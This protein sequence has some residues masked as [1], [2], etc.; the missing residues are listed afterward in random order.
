MRWAAR[1]TRVQAEG[2][3]GLT[4]CLRYCLPCSAPPRSMSAKNFCVRSTFCGMTDSHWFTSASG[5]NRSISFIMR[6]CSRSITAVWSGCTSGKRAEDVLTMAGDPNERA[7]VEA[8]QDERPE[9]PRAED[10]REARVER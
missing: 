8:R 5:E 4:S 10:R 3:G 6:A 7:P 2:Y 1:D 9:R